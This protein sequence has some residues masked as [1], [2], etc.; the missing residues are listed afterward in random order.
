MLFPNRQ[1][2]PRAFPTAHTS[3]NY[4][5]KRRIGQGQPETPVGSH[6][7]WV[8]TVVFVVRNGIVPYPRQRRSYNILAIGPR[9][10]PSY[11]VNNISDTWNSSAMELDHIHLLKKDYNVLSSTKPMPHPSLLHTFRLLPIH[12]LNKLDNMGISWS[13]LVK[14]I[15]YKT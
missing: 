9:I 1:Q 2:Y 15:S 10:E 11:A 7:L 4:C 13:S 3:S 14:D 8:L 5:P 12:K 6:N